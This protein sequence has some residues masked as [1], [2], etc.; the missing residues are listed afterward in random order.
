MPGD[1]KNCD[2]PTLIAKSRQKGWGMSLHLENLA[3]MEH[4]VI[5]RLETRV[6]EFPAHHTRSISSLKSALSEDIDKF[7]HAFVFPADVCDITS[8]LHNQMASQRKLL[9]LLSDVSRGESK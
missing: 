1:G 4:Q 8:R 3:W 6:G 9:D 2:F 7:R 5:D